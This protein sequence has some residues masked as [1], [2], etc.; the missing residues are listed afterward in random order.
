MID[1]SFFMHT[2]K[3][4]NFI[5]VTKQFLMSMPISQHLGFDIT[6]VALGRFEITQ[7]FHRELS[8]CEST[9]QAGFRRVPSAP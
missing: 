1:E 7:P 9:F 8:F 6:D 3:S 5:D 4:E 2:A